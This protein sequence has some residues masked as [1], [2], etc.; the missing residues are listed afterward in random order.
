MRWAGDMARVGDER[1]VYRVL[2][3]NPEGKR[4]LGRK[5]RRWKNGIIMYLT[6]DWQWKVCGVGSLGSV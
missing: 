5:R 2:V 6:G 3:G 1:K 4:P